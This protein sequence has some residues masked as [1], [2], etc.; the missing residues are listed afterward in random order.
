[1]ENENKKPVT[2][3]PHW[4]ARPISAELVRLENYCFVD[5]VFPRI[6]IGLAVVGIAAS[7]SQDIG[8]PDAE[9][10]T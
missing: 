3:L 7:R 1:L 8:M 6:Y 2:A 10:I 5:G 4:E 9:L